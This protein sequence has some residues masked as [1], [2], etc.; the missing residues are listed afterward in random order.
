[1][2]TISVIVPVYNVEKYLHTCIESILRQ[3]FGDFDLILINDGST[4]NSGNICD[5][6]ANKDERIVV[7]HQSNQGQAIARNAGLDYCYNNS[8][9]KWIAFID[10]DDYIHP[11]YLEILLNAVTITNQKISA[12]KYTNDTMNDCKLLQPK[13]TVLD[14]EDFFCNNN[15]LAIV[16]V[17]KLFHKD[18][19]EN[20]RYP[21][22]MMCED[23]ATIFR[24]LFQCRQIV[25]VDYELYYYFLNNS[26]TMLSEWTPRRLAAIDAVRQQIEFFKENEYQQAYKISVC[27]LLWIYSSYIDKTKGKK[28]Y[29][30]YRKNFKKELKLLLKKYEKELNFSKYRQGLYY[31][32]AYPFEMKVYW[33]IQGIKKHLT[34]KK[35]D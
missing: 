2:A 3:S 17:V 16:P 10:S 30:N 29:K 33:N 5:E 6:Y 20:V 31:E 25:F 12:C 21:K 27:N 14:T 26:G 28:I 11:Q 34:S 24:A 22:M 7:F 4:D 35:K 1:M 8:D 32:R 15:T 18:C 19:F 23:E 9:S 13:Y